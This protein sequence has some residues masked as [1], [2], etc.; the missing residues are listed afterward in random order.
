MGDYINKLLDPGNWPSI[1]ATLGSF[2]FFGFIVYSLLCFPHPYRPDIPLP[3]DQ[4]SVGPDTNLSWIGGN[5]SHWAIYTVTSLFGVKLNP[6][7]IY[8]ITIYNGSREIYRGIEIGDYK[9]TRINHKASIKFIQG[10][11]Y[12]WNVTAENN[13][14]RS[15]SGQK[16]KFAIK[17]TPMI[18]F[19]GK[20]PDQSNGSNIS[21]TRITNNS[22]N[23]SYNLTKNGYVSLWAPIENELLST[24]GLMLNYYGGGKTNSFELML[25]YN[26]GDN[27]TN[28]TR[29]FW[30]DRAIKTNSSE[31]RNNT[32]EF[33]YSELVKGW[34]KAHNYGHL[35]PIDKDK[36]CGIYI[37]IENLP[38][39]GDVNGTGWI[40]LSNLHGIIE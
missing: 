37:Y 20:Y 36:I 10:Y 8:N 22:I 11:E 1:A 32:K 12:I 31:W 34:N 23:I 4:S 28:E 5:P 38:D 9:R 33:Q 7:L 18:K 40:N 24:K 13:F 14:E 35:D 2:L 39:Y 26:D 27:N 21:E 6:E 29:Y 30:F 17:N 15:T 19:S 25:V 3:S 16:W